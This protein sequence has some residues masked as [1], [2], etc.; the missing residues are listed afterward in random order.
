MMTKPISKAK[1]KAAPKR[2]RMHLR[3]DVAT[4][5]KLERAAA[6]TQKSVTDFVLSQAVEAADQGLKAHEQHLSLPPTGKPSV[7]PSTAPQAESRIEA[8]LPV[9]P[10]HHDLGTGMPLTLPPIIEPLTRKHDRERFDCGIPI[11]NEYLQRQTAQDTRR[12]VSR[13]YVARTQGSMVIHGYYTL[14]ATSIG[15]E[16]LPDTEAKHLPHYPIPAALLGRLAV[17][18]SHQGQ[19]LGKYLLF[20]AFHGCSRLRKRLPSTR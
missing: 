6:Y 9:V 1:S 19:M 8:R 20:D 13:V 15:K 14:S 5:R 18:R 3:L 11:L 10:G 2:D 17:H 16:N 4:K 12:G 7:K